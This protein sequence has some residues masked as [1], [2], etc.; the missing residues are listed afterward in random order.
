M[1]FHKSYLIIGLL[2]I[3]LGAAISDGELKVLLPGICESHTLF[4]DKVRDYIKT[5]SKLLQFF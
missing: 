1:F 2:D 3:H 5:V 4:A